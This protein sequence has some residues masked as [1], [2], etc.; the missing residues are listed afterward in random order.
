M[1]RHWP[2]K[3]FLSWKI[4]E[5]FQPFL[6]MVLLKTSCRNFIHTIRWKSLNFVEWIIVYIQYQNLAS[7]YLALSFNFLSKTQIIYPWKNEVKNNHGLVVVT[8]VTNIARNALTTCGWS[9]VYQGAHAPICMKPF[10]FWYLWLLGYGSCDRLSLFIKGHYSVSWLVLKVFW[11]YKYYQPIEIWNAIR[12]W[13]IK[14]VLLC[15]IWTCFV[16]KVRS[17]SFIFGNIFP[18]N[19]DWFY[20]LFS[21]RSPVLLISA[22]CSWQYE[23]DITLTWLILTAGSFKVW[24]N[25]I[26]A[27]FYPEQMSFS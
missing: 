3:I 5:L 21:S 14:F 27:S 22:F 25:W 4:K 26:F 19:L 24:I 20:H 17:S 1:Q 15:K 13:H 6:H 12:I 8:Y 9:L 18:I 11:I 10:F 23:E 16:W 7:K 2:R